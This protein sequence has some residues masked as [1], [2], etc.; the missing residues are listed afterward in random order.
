MLDFQLNVLI[1][2]FPIF[3]LLCIYSVSIFSQQNI[4]PF[5]KMHGSEN[6]DLF[7]TFYNI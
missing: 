6:W 3:G 5:S 1:V 2:T 4:V 7:K